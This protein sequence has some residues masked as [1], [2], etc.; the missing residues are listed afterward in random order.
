MYCKEYHP[1]ATEI[2]NFLKSKSV[3]FDILE[4]AE[5]VTSEEA[6]QV[7]DGFSLQEGVKALI[8]K[9]KNA[10]GAEYKFIQL[11]IPGDR[12][13][14]SSKVRALLS[15]KEVRFANENELSTITKDVK[16]GGVPPVGNVFFNLPLYV[17]EKVFQNKRMVFNCGDRCMSIALSTKDYA[18]VFKP[19]IV[20]ISS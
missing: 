5:V 18:D 4:H 7:R 1:L 3:E 9:C 10:R 16:P 8:V 14:S 15:V 6:S 11:C 2:V 19:A 12:K 17:D 20:D 13:F